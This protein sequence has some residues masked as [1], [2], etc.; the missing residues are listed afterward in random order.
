MRC[1]SCK[2]DAS[3]ST[4]KPFCSERCRTL[5]LAKWLDGHY[6]IAG[7]PVDPTTLN[8]MADG[9]IHGEGNA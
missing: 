6:R 1:P 2:A 8:D 3:K 7:E 4:A 9:P 5:D